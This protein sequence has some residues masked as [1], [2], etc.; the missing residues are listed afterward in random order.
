VGTDPGTRSFDIFGMNREGVP[1]IDESFNYSDLPHRLLEVLEPLK[2]RIECFI[3]PSG[4]GTAF[5][6]LEEAGEE[7]LREILPREDPRIP[8]NETIRILFW[9]L[10]RLRVPSYLLPGVI[11]LPTVPKYRK[12]NKLDM[13]TAD[14]LCV[15][16]LAI[17]SQMCRFNF[18]ASKAN[19]IL[20]ELG[21]GFNACLVVED[22]KII[23]G[24]GGT[25]G[26]LGFLSPG[27]VDAELAIRMPV[28]SQFV[29]FTSGA[30]RL[31][32]NIEPEELPQHP[33]A[34]K[35]FMEGVR[36]MVAQ[37][38]T[39]NPDPLELIVSGRLSTLPELRAELSLYANKLQ[40]HWLRDWAGRR[41]KRA[42]EAAEGAGILAAGIAGWEPYKHI[43]TQL[44]VARSGGRIWDY[45]AMD[46][47]LEY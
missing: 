36:K 47:T 18:P 29:L 6:R 28:C 16:A 25:S 22:G 20:L 17:Y 39:V 14:K 4:Y 34:W 24:L 1:V 27:A 26:S 19:F 10:R 12:V 2:E 37:A 45:V 5:K 41:A 30:R 13:G 7:D 31:G 43:F 23:D 9:E 32:G 11:H 42:K 46:V 3:A 35:A 44:E 21:Y 40:I 8:V 15:A 33:E 38:L